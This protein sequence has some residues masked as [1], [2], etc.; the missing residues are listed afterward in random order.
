MNRLTCWHG[1][2]ATAALI[3]SSAAWAAAPDALEP[4]S[5]PVAA[6]PAPM[7]PLTVYELNTEMVVKNWVLCVSADRAEQLV[8]AREQGVEHAISAFRDLQQAKSCGRVSE[9]RVIL[10]ER[11]YA[12]PAGSEHG[13]RAFG[14]LIGVFDKW[15]SAYLVVGGLPD[16]E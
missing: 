1:A 8:W 3:V 12:S 16:A 5:T 10:Q 14:A 7:P 9:L 4:Q 13:A 15:A 6:A 2:A 11:L